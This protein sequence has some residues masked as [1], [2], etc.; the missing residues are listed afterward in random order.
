MYH[1][2]MATSWMERARTLMQSRGISQEALAVSISCTRGAVGHYL[3][4]RRSPSL[5]QMNRIAAALQADPAWLL[6]GVDGDGIR[7]GGA[8][9]HGPAAFVPLAGEIGN[10]ARRRVHGHVSLAVAA[11]CY[12]V[13]ITSNDYEPRIHAGE[14]VLVD[15]ATEPCPGDEIAVYFKDHSIQLRSLLKVSKGRITVDNIVGEKE[16][17]ALAQRDY[18]A[19]H[20]VVAIFTPVREVGSE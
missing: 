6:F 14:A 19:I 13:L 20:R 12:A 2:A 10:H 18:R 16:V 8:A 7:E 11:D 4:G 3:N 9:Y 5:E 15:P 17:R 1:F